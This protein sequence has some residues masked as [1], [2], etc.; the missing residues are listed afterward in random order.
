MGGNEVGRRGGWSG[1]RCCLR[2]RLGK[3]IDCAVVI[4]MLHFCI[5]GKND[6]D[7]CLESLWK[8][9]NGLKMRREKG[10]SS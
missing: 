7:M 4:K 1:F 5:L 9:N 3:A 2:E 6:L 8:G 10:D